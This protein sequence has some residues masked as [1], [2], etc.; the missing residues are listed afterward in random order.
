MCAL[1]RS[2]VGPQ[3][4]V[5]AL[6][7]LGAASCSSDSGRFSDVFGSDSASRNEATGSIPQGT[8]PRREPAPAAPG[9]QCR[10]GGLRRRPGHGLLPARQQ[11][12]D[13]LL[14][15]SGPTAAGLDL[16]RWHPD[17]GGPWREPRNAVA[18]VRRASRGHHGGQQH[19]GSGHGASRPTSGYSAPSRTSGGP[20]SAADAHCHDRGDRALEPRRSAHRGPRS[21]RPRASMSWRRARHSTALRG[22]TASRCWRW[23][24]P[25]TFRRTPW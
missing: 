14:A 10:R 18:A 21:R 13:R 11:R 17:H 9:Q 20:G 15:A 22:S 1:R 23:P 4:V 19:H 2:A 3:L 7:G 25:T 24:R 8:Q 12:G 16:G 5:I 6:I